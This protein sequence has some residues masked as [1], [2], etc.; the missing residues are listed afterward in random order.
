MGFLPVILMGVY[1]CIQGCVNRPVKVVERFSRCG[2]VQGADRFEVW[3]G[4]SCGA[5][6]Y[7][8]QCYAPIKIIGIKIIRSIKNDK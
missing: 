6:L 2:P 1:R 8:A 4:S 3:T 5:V 7:S